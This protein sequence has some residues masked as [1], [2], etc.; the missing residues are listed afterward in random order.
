M[1][2]E[3]KDFRFPDEMLNPEQ[4]GKNN[5]NLILRVE[6]II[7]MILKY[8]KTLSEKMSGSNKEITDCAI[9][10]PSHWGFN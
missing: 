4:K 2:F 7:A 1:A 9:T 8:A 10:V 6:D 3:L 5:K